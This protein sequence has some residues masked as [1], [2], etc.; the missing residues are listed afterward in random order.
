MERKSRV[1]G[2]GERKNC[3]HL[4]KKY[5]GL[6]LNNVQSSIKPQRNPVG[7]KKAPSQRIIMTQ[8]GLIVRTE[9]KRNLR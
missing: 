4:R 5:A 7:K 1:W 3:N 8:D 2:E 6:L 9:F